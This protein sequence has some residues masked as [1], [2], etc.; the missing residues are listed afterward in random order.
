[1]TF[2]FRKDT[3][4]GLNRLWSARRKNCVSSVECLNVV[5]CVR[6]SAFKAAIQ[7]EPEREDL[8]LRLVDQL[9]SQVKLYQRFGLH[10]KMGCMLNEL[11]AVVG[12]LQEP[13]KSL[14]HWECM[15]MKA[16]LFWSRNEVDN[17]LRFIKLLCRELSDVYVVIMKCWVV[18]ATL[19]FR[20]IYPKA[21]CCTAMSC[22][23]VEIGSLRV[24]P[25]VRLKL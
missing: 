19:F 11:D 6:T 16:E 9:K 25:K 18:S 12:R 24:N 23:S 22:C 17:A 5:S 1:M 21:R 3:L 13:Q 15:K 2:L 7:H 14:A 10:Q 20:P 4:G 8:I